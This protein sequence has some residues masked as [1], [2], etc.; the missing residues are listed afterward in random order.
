MSIFQQLNISSSALTSNRLRMDLISSN[1]A[2]ATTTRGSLVNGEWVPYRRKTAVVTPRSATP[3]E[4]F[5]DQAVQQGNGKGLEGVR[6]TRIVEDQTPFKQVYEPSH[7]DANGEGYVQM[8]NVDIT[9][10]MVDLMSA[11]RAYEANVTA[12]NAGKNMDLKAL[13]IGK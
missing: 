9:K 12:F 5:L 3:F 6:V 4:S 11:T 1:I 7:P 10:E 13:E 8:P 2:N